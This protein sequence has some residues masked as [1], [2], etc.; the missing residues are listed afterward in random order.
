MSILPK[1][2]LVDR[3]LDAIEDNRPL[4]WVERDTGIPIYEIRTIARVAGKSK[5]QRVDLAIY[6][7]VEKAVEDG[8]S[9]GEIARTYG[10]HIYTIR[11][12]FPRSGWKQGGSQEHTAYVS[13]LR[14]MEGGHYA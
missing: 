2:H 9:L 4:R 7:Q 14:N 3:A 11:Q 1:R 12:W 13:G 6:D 10:W 5:G 8:W